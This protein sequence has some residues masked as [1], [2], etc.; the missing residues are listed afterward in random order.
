M[1]IFER[2]SR[3]RAKPEGKPKATVEWYHRLL[4]RTLL[5]PRKS[6]IAFAMRTS[7]NA[8][9]PVN[10]KKST[11]VGSMRKEAKTHLVSFRRS[12]HHFLVPILLSQSYPRH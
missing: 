9:P 12:S 5:G 1:P 8:K 4:P 3:V 7:L 10:P 11:R 6:P 2:K